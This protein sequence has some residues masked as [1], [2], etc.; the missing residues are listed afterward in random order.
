MPNVMSHFSCGV[1]SAV[2]TKLAIERF[3]EVNIFYC[4][5]HSEHPDNARF[6][7][8]CERWFGRPVR[9]VQSKAYRNTWDVF[10]RTRFLSSPQGA[11][12][13]SE[14]K[15]I[16][17]Q[18]F[19]SIGTIEVFGYTADEQKR[20]DRF[21]AQNE[22]RI[23]V[24]PLIDAGLTKT[25]CFNMIKSAAIDLPMMYKLGFRNNNCIACVKARDNINYWKRIRKYFP[26]EFKRMAAL[27][28][29]LSFPLNRITKK[30][31]RKTIYLDEIPAGDPKGKDKSVSC[32]IVCGSH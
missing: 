5:T 26:D 21:K 28:R 29:E 11:R 8:D 6:L 4:A 22:E 9:T 27:E 18:E 19:W 10:E 14:L 7:A 30:K 1:A 12:C 32:G 20:V 3:P 25:D 23:I 17:A 2:A 15:R 31:D 16:P 24:C 13:T